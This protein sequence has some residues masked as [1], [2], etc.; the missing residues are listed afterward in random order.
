MYSCMVFCDISK[1]FIKVW[2]KGLLFELRQNG[3]KGNLLVCI[4][5]YLSSHKQRVQIN[6]TMSSLL[7]VN[8]GVPPGVC[9]GATS[10]PS[11]C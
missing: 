1:A 5:N 2:H 6:P 9:P 7:S 4:S 8:A 10:F 3:I 11:V